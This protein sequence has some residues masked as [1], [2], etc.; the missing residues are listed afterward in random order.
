MT[1]VM[2]KDLEVPVLSGYNFAI[3][4]RLF[5]FAMRRE[6]SA[7]G[8]YSVMGLTCAGLLYREWRRTR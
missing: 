6:P 1:A 2:K 8:M 3:M 7:K 4:K 5:H